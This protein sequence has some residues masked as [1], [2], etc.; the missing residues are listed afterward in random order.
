MELL[1]I[2][3]YLTDFIYNIPKRVKSHFMAAKFFSEPLKDNA[4]L[5]S[6]TNNKSSMCKSFTFEK[7]EKH[8]IYL[9]HAL[10]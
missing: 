1:I 4:T 9:G 6:V 8:Q 7:Y 3:R 2:D 10:K 5:I